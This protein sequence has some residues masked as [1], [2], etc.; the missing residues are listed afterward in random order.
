MGANK[1]IKDIEA[2]RLAATRSPLLVR[3]RKLS[4]SRRSNLAGFWKVDLCRRASEASYRLGVLHS[5]PA[6]LGAGLI[7]CTHIGL[8]RALGY[9]LKYS[10]GFQY[11]HLGRIG[12][13]QQPTPPSHYGNRPR[14]RGVDC[15]LRRDNCFVNGMMYTTAPGLTGNWKAEVCSDCVYIIVQFH[16]LH[17][18]VRRNAAHQED[19]A[20]LARP[21]LAGANFR[22]SASPETLAPLSMVPARCLRLVQAQATARSANEPAPCARQARPPDQRL[23]ASETDSARK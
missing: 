21:K 9:G 5:Q 14:R 15:P 10:T 16:S 18:C 1:P 4:V 20:F 13:R 11:T 17:P 8:D 3:L 6:A 23:P 22:L 19:L 12:R 2:T 7:W